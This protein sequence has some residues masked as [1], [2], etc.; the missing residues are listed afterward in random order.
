MS[1]L[2]SQVGIV[3]GAGGKSIRNIRESTG[4]V[5]IQVSVNAARCHV[6]SLQGSAQRHA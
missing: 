6:H 1:T 4:C 3:I 2:C 5:S